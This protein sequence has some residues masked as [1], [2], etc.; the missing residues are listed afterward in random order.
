MRNV[1]ERLLNLLAFLLTARRPVTADEI[2]HTVAGYGQ[3]TDEA[4]R[5]MFER[6]KEVLRAMG[7]PLEMRPLD[8]WEAEFGYVVDPRRYRLPEIDLSDDELAALWLAAQVVR[9]GGE[10]QGPEALLKLGGARVT[11]G[12]EPLAADLGAEAGILGDLFGA[13]AERRR[14]RFRYRDRERSVEPYGLG[15][16]RGHWYLVAAEEGESRVYRV[17][18]AHDLSVAGEAG[19]FRPP[20]GFDLRSELDLAPWEAGT[21]APV[22]AEVVFDPEVSWWATQRLG[23][24]VEA[25][26]RDDGSLLVR[27]GVTNPEAFV[28]WVLTFGAHAEVIAPVELRRRVVDRVRGVA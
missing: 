22:T 6:D 15:H 7:I 14:V 1:L 27:M 25:D 2:R 21:E 19:A 24:G 3:D 11:S 16:R 8:A 5:R 12:V 26:T 10:Q 18:R 20:E 13:V 23:H 17:D 9:I 4:F 28:G